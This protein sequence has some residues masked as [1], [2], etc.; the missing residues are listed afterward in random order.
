MPAEDEMLETVT[1]SFSDVAKTVMTSP[2]AGV[3]EDDVHDE[4]EYDVSTDT[5]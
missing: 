1:D 3:N 5:N 4:F 2:T